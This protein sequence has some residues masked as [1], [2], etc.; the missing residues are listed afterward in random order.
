MRLATHGVAGRWRP[1]SPLRWTVA[2]LATGSLACSSSGPSQQTSP[3]AGHFV[4]DNPFATPGFALALSLSVTG[5]T[6]TGNG[7]LSGL[8]NPLT[9]LSV[10]GEFSDPAFSLT[11][12]TLS[13]YS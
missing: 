6:V 12:T 4:A 9:P 13:G 8:E 1:L 7:W 11:L 2:A 3:L 10:T 5:T